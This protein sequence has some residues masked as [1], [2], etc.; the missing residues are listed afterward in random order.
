MDTAIAPSMTP[1]PLYMG[2]MDQSVSPVFASSAGNDNSSRPAIT[3]VLANKPLPGAV[4]TQPVTITDAPAAIPVT[5]KK[6]IPLDAQDI[7]NGLTSQNPEQKLNAVNLMNKQDAATADFHPNTQPQWGAMLVSAL[8]HDWAGVHKYYNG[9]P[10]RDE[11]ARDLNNNIYFKQF[12]ANG[13]TG[14]Y[15][16]NQGKIL[17]QTQ[18]DAL[19]ARGG[20]ISDSDRKV[21]ETAPWVNGKAN[22]ILYNNA[23]TG[24]VPLALNG[25]Y[26]A[27]NL[28]NASNKNIDEQLYIINNPKNS[29]VRNLL[30]LISQTSPEARQRILGLVNQLKTKGVNSGTAN[31]NSGSATGSTATTTGN[32]SNL[33][34]G[35]S[36]SVPGATANTPNVVIPGAVIPGV[37]V[38]G[39]VGTSASST[40]QGTTTASQQNVANTANTDTTQQQE[41]VRSLIEKELQGAIKNP[42]LKIQKQDFDNYMRIQALDAQNKAASASIPPNFM[43]PGY[44]NITESDLQLGGSK[45][46]IA[47]GVERKKNN[48][49]MAAWSNELFKSVRDAANNPGTRVDLNEVQNNFK[50]SDIHKAINNTFAHHMSL[51]MGA[52]SP[53]QAGDLIVDPKTNE[54]GKYPKR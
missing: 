30:D 17:N 19:N 28:A 27:A 45:A 39:G 5:Q 9:G 6:D 34:G 20:V 32:T 50:N 1:L 33:G 52:P 16:D 21:I 14:V 46:L 51:E 10:T 13:A 47:N 44:T 35:T 23:L 11:E 18:L 8:S 7:V 48:N 12:N 36:I 22:S 49:L 37:S 42:D 53:L 2:D 38:K 15:K 54:I 25:A 29:G 26:Q 40:V 24:P 41:N 3:D 4:T 43:P 31:T